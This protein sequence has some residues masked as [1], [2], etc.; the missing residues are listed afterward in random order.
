MT[1]SAG[2]FGS[3]GCLG[4]APRPVWALWSSRMRRARRPSPSASSA[5][6]FAFPVSLGPAPTPA[7][8]LWSSRMR[9]ARRPTPS[10]SSSGCSAFPGCLGPTPKPASELW[11]SGMQEARRPAPTS[12]SGCF[13]C[14]MCL[15]LTP[16]PTLELWGCSSAPGLALELWGPQRPK[17]IRSPPSSPS[18]ALC[19]Q[20]SGSPS[21][22]W[23][24]LESTVG[25]PSKTP[26]S[27]S[28]V[29][30]NHLRSSQSLASAK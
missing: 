29:V 13:A 20:P 5:G 11:S 4:L 14:P 2:C 18:S 10:T 25:K 21:Q 8:A 1:S 9:W 30:G 26:S 19:W 22:A 3:S 17:A 6:C 24:R 27:P 12:S 16:R 23:A 7:S 15:G 28:E